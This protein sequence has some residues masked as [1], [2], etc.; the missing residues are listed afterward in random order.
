MFV[1]DFHRFHVFSFISLIFNFVSDLNVFQY[2][3]VI[4][5]RETDCGWILAKLWIWEHVFTIKATSKQTQCNTKIKI[6]LRMDVK[7]TQ[8]WNKS[9]NRCKFA[10]K[11]F[12]LDSR[13]PV[14]LRKY[15][16]NQSNIKANSMQ[17]INENNS[18]HGRQTYT[19]L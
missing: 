2:F 17:H 15:V 3:S 7:P 5:S 1:W 14:N 13:K 16:H 8:I 19:N 6:N 10:W 9:S 4:Y 11:Q 12:W 18:A